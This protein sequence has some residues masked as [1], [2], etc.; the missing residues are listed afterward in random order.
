[1]AKIEDYTIFVKY[2]SFF[3][4]YLDR[5][6]KFPRV[7][8]FTIGDKLINLLSEIQDGI[9]EAI[10]TKDKVYILRKTNL[11]IEKLRIYTRL[12]SERKYISIKQHEYIS[13][14]LNEIGKMIGG[15]INLCKE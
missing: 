14:E 6:E 4:Y 1:M 9:I 7:S 8:K 10:Y 13:N 3:K 11:N 2:Y 5:I 12:S 15:W